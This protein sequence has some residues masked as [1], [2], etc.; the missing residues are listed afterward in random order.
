MARATGV[1]RL[2]LGSCTCSSLPCKQGSEPMLG[3]SLQGG[4]PSG[5]QGHITSTACHSWGH[6]N[7]RQ[8][9][10]EDMLNLWWTAHLCLPGGPSRTSVKEGATHSSP[11][12]AGLWDPLGAPVAGAR[13]RAQLDG[14]QHQSSNRG[15]L[16]EEV[17]HSRGA[18]GYLEA[19][20]AGVQVQ[21]GVACNMARRGFG[22]NKCCR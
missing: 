15:W 6:L 13:R 14:L 17:V 9:E 18:A 21:P 5:Q 19:A 11:M 22:C 1:E 16:E 8:G 4:R 7:C 12:A 20:G 2:G 3:R 10:Q